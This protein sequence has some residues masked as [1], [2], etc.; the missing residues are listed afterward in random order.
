[1]RAFLDPAGKL[2]P[3][4]SYVEGVERLRQLQHEIKRIDRQLGSEGHLWRAPWKRDN[5]I[6]KIEELRSEEHQLEDW[7]NNKK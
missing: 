6:K 7:L 1:M 4:P 5:A 3:P 2:L